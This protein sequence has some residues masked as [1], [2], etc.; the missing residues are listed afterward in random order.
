MLQNQ[1]LHNAQNYFF[2]WLREM[3]EQYQEIERMREQDEIQEEALNV[4]R[5]SFEKVIVW[6]QEY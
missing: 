1:L 3:Q 2:L 4:A 5:D 6:K